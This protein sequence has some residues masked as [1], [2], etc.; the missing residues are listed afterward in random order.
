[1]CN[2]V[3]LDSPVESVTD[4]GCADGWVSVEDDASEETLSSVEW[5]S[6]EVCVAVDSCDVVDCICG[7]VLAIDDTCVIV[8]LL[9]DDFKV[10]KDIFLV[11]GCVCDDVSVTGDSGASPEVLP[12]ERSP[13]IDGICAMVE[14][15]AVSNDP[16]GDASIS[17]G[18]IA[19]DDIC[20]VVG[21]VSDEDIVPADVCVVVG[22]I[23]D[24][25]AVIDDLWAWVPWRSDE[26]SV[27]DVNCD[28]DELDAGVEGLCDNAR[29]DE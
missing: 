23:S 29:A 12:A 16:C 10:L 28:V 6:D 9:S 13:V 15:N 24:D 27:I 2:V 19:S 11:V 18:D 5:V 3:R 4:G 26:D 20:A 7:E 22:Y 8:G 1:N 25:V 21:C 17:D 14:L